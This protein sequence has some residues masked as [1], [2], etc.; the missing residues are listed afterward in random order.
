MK[1]VYE[2]LRT[3]NGKFVFLNLHQRRLE[4]SCK[5][6]GLRSPK[7]SEIL[8]DFIGRRDVR[9]KVEIDETLGAK[10]S[11]E[12]LEDW[13]GSF[14]YD[15]IWRIELVDFERDNPEI[16]N[17]DTSRKDEARRSSGADEVLLVN[18]FGEITEGSIT[19]IFFVK[20]GALITPSESILKGIAREVILD[21]VK[22]LGISVIERTVTKSEF[23]TG[24]FDGL[25]LSNSIRGIIRVAPN[26]KVDLLISKLAKNIEEKINKNYWNS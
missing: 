23:E 26:E 13:N 6:H 22:E 7:L 20:D 25:F 2:A 21:A 10:I 16:K 4:K 5:A 18:R 12:K 17:A 24:A 3:W 11:E 19:N 15:K 14:V 9:L 1:G 8:K